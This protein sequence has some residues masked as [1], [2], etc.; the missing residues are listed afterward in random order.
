MIEAFVTNMKKYS[1]GQSLGEWLKLPATKNELKTLL[2]NIGVDGNVHKNVF[3][4]DYRHQIEKLEGRFQEHENIDELNYLA[5]ILKN[6]DERTLNKFEAILEYGFYSK[7]TKDLINLT[8]NMDCY[9]YE[10]D[11]TNHEQLG[12]HYMDNMEIKRTP[13]TDY[14]TYGRDQANAENGVFTKDGYVT[15]N[16]NPF[17]EHYK[18]QYQ[19][20]KE[21]KIFEYPDPPSKMPIK[22]QLEMFSKMAMTYPQKETP[23]MVRE[24]NER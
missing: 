5:T 21:Q 3:I 14:E 15:E 24:G 6:M 17:I 22:H 16:K 9:D 13:N 12:K 11:I 19:L 1:E 10:L 18:G 20:T 23:L 8:K 2:Q 7:D 4:T